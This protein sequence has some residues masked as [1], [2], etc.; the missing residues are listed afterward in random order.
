VDRLQ[1]E[2][3]AG[4]AVGAVIA[5]L[6]ADLRIQLLGAERLS[7]IVVPTGG[8]AAAEEPHTRLVALLE[9]LV[10]ETKAASGQRPIDFNFAA[11]FPLESPFL[12][13]YSHVYRTSVRRLMQSFERR[14]GVRLWCSVRRSGKTTA[15]ATDLGSTSGQSVV[16]AQTCDST[17]QMADGDVFY[18]AI[19]RALKSG[20]RL[21]ED[22]VSSTVARCL[23]AATD[24]RVVLVLD[25]YETLFGDLRTSMTRD[26]GLRYTVVQ[27]LLNQLVA[28]TRD[29]LLIFMGQQPNA[30]WILTD[31]NQLSP[32]VMQDPFP[33]FSHDP[34]ASSVSEFRELVQK[35]MSSHVDLHPD[36][37]NLLYAETGGH[38]FLTGKL[39]V[40]FWDWLIDSQR[41]SSCLAPV[42]PELFLEFTG[43]C[44]GHASI[45]HNH[46]YEMFKRAAADHLSPTGR[47]NEPW[48]H[49]VYSALRALVLTSPETFSLPLDQF[50]AL[51]ERTGAGTSPE[52]LLSTATRANFLMLE[53]GVVRPPI[54]LLARIAAAVRPL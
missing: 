31:Q 46:H 7:D 25:E 11:E 52:D 49:S 19:R 26:P 51:A 1:I 15:C 42:S 28:F 24:A 48:L 20:E 41:P 12:T 34:A 54:R 40:S 37:V 10:F 36:F 23:S 13:R 29:N 18:G 3:A 6:R 8:G 33:L 38:P 22:F 53:S 30:H 2:E 4:R 43:S 21:E 50:I 32:V 47:A 39:L 14:N 16:V 44:L 17:G 27:P 5:P 45:A 9:D 35:M